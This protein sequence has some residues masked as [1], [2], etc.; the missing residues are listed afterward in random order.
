MTSGCWNGQWPPPDAPVPEAV[1]ASRVETADRELPSPPD[2]SPPPELTEGCHQFMFL[3]GVLQLDLHAKVLN[4]LWSESLKV[5]LELL[6]DQAFERRL[7]SQD[8]P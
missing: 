5:T 4:S 6:G 3:P 8:A 2:H 7:R 1:T